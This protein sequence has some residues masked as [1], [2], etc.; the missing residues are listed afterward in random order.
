MNWPITKL[1]DVCTFM[2]GGTPKTSVPEY[3][4]GGDIRWI[5]SGDIHKGEIFDCE[6]RITQKGL[7]NS[8]TKFLPINS[9]LIALNGQGKTRGTVALLRHEKATCNQSVVSINPISQETLDTYYL[10]VVLRTMYKKIR[11]ITGDKDRAGLNIPILK[12]IQI[13]I[14]PIKEQKR[15]SAILDKADG[16]RRKRQQAIEL[17]DQ[18]LRSVF[19]DMF[20]DPV[21]NPKGFEIK[22]LKDIARIQIGPFGT[23]LHKEDY[24]EGGVPLINPTHIVNGRVAPK[25]NLSISNVKHSTLSEYHL[26]QGD[27]IMGRRG[28]MGRCALITEKEKGWMCGTGSLFIRP[29]VTGV[30]SEYLYTLLS[31]TAIKKYLEGESLGAT[32]PNLNKGIVGNIKIPVPDERTIKKYSQIRKKY[33]VYKN[34]LSLFSDKEL[35]ESLTQQAFNG[36]LTK[37]IKAA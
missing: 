33:D 25:S 23:Q 36:K 13:P 37:Q 4:E 32:M 7:D 15:I 6:K 11:N 1:G 8:N 21:T 2:T 20:G 3:Y 18:L 19:L 34:K 29:K 24:I 16:L 28:E 35:F 5:V 9:V 30:F 27:I 31:S 26:E 17:T 14:P 12:N 10:F 22:N